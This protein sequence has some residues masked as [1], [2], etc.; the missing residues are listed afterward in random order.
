[1]VICFCDFCGDEFSFYEKIPSS[2]LNIR[3]F[4]FNNIKLIYN[5]REL[6]TLEELK[7]VNNKSRDVRS[8]ENQMA[9]SLQRKP[10]QMAHYA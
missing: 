6:Y 8:Y 4:K 9:I 3:V 2:P 5:A 10:E 1:M 7:P